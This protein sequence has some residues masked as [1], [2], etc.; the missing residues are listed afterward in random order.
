M[1]NR[2]SMFRLT[3]IASL[4]LAIGLVSAASASAITTIGQLGVPSPSNCAGA[5]IDYVQPTV[6]SG[7]SYVVPAGSGQ[8]IVSWSFNAPTGANQAATMKVYEPVS[9]AANQ[10]KVVAHDGPHPLTASIKNTF[11]TSIAVKPG[12]LLGMTKPS[13]VSTGCSFSAPGETGL[14]YSPFTDYMDGQTGTFNSLSNDF[15][16]NISADVASPPSN[17]FVL[18]KV[19]KN[20]NKG[21]A[22]LTV[23]VPGPGTL[24][25]SGGGL[26]AQRV[27]GASISKAVSSAGPVHLKVK[28][29]G[30]KKTKLLHNGKIKVK[31]TVTY[32][33]TGDLPGVAKTETQPIKLVK[34]G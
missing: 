33:P 1:S 24:T 25:L 10:Y 23:N 2:S 14:R 18:G 29:K 19:K 28:A 7:T 17:D 30:H 9:A 4:T 13:G 27:G 5:S 6:S 15:R 8:K 26:K 16:L 34:K 12:D 20:K 3:L 31:A 32:T 22:V 21:T 11:T